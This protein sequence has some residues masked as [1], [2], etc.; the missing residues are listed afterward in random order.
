MWASQSLTSITWGIPRHTHKLVIIVHHTITTISNDTILGQTDRSITT[1]TLGVGH[2][3]DRTIQIIVYTVGKVDL[4]MVLLIYQP[5][6][7][8]VSIMA[9][10]NLTI[11]SVAAPGPIMA[12]FMDRLGLT[13]T[14]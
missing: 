7:T 13:M 14:L 11:L 2:T 9:K 8:V 5:V 6:L 3:M 1:I 4:I 10:T 12:P